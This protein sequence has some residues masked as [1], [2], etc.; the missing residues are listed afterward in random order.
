[1]QKTILNADDDIDVIIFVS[2]VLEKAGYK[3]VGAK[4]GEEALNKIREN[5]PDLIIL[6]IL[7]PKQSGIKAYRELKTDESLKDI[8][9]VILSG[10]SKRTFLRS[11]EALTEFGGEAVPEPEAYME[12]PV[13]PED[14]AQTVREVLSRKGG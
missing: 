5:K 9:V 11:Q 3:V 10:I 7:M 8:P 6:D 14:L 12:K 13:E 4:N 2:S 1:M